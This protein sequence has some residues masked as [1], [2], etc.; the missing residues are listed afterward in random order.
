MTVRH[1]Q[2][3]SQ[4]WP[5]QHDICPDCWV[6]THEEAAE[7]AGRLRMVYQTHAPY[8]AEMIL[9]MLNNEGIPSMRVPGH[10]AVLWPMATAS[11]LEPRTQLRRLTP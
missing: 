8:E 3:C 5:D 9:G 6:P 7:P 11:P 1:C 10:G 2:E 4:E